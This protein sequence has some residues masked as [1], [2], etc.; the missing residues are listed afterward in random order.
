MN[1]VTAEQSREIDRLTIEG[2]VAG[3]ALMENA[4]HRVAETI[5]QEFDPISKH[6]LII[7]CGKGN[8]GGDG[9]AL[10]RLMIGKVAKL[11]VVI[12]A[13]QHEY[14]GDALVNLERLIAD[15]VAPQLEIPRNFASAARS[16]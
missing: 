3:I 14:I 8:N 7:L 10:A 16:P 13:R 5:E 12:A 15:G 2:G 11:R 1:V 4:A 9:L 6:N